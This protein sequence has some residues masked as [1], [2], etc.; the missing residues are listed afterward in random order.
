MANTISAAIVQTEWTGDVDSM[1]KVVR[2]LDLDMIDTVRKTWIF[3]RNR[4]PDTY[5]DL[6]VP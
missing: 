5:G 6:V 3:H 2:D 4:R 1:I